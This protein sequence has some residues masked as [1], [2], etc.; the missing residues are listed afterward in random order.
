MPT[1]LTHWYDENDEILAVGDRVLVN[2]SIEGVICA[3]S[4]NEL[5]I[6]GLP[7]GTIVESVQ[8]L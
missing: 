5:C 7:E 8:K 3:D 4:S 6:E 1:K 2:S